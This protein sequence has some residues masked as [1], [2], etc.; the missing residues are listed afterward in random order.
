MYWQSLTFAVMLDS[1]RD[2]GLLE[3]M[4]IRLPGSQKMTSMSRKTFYICKCAGPACSLLTELRTVS[5]CPAGR[6][7]CPAVL[8]LRTMAPGPLPTACLSGPVQGSA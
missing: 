3:W 2:M 5:D 8:A 1:A 6:T 4:N 7:T